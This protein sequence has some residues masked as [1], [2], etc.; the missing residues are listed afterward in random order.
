MASRTPTTS[1]LPLIPRRRPHKKSRTGCAEC[2]KRRIKCGEEKPRC[3]SCTRL[4]IPCP[5]PPAKT[6][7]TTSSLSPGTGSDTARARFTSSPHTADNAEFFSTPLPIPDLAGTDRALT[8][9]TINDLA[10]LHHWT[11]ST[12]R[13]IVMSPGVDHYWQRIFPQIAFQHPFLMH[14]IISLAALHL[15]FVHPEN[16][17]Q[18]ILDATSHHNRALEG[19]RAGLAGISDENSDALFACASVNII[20]V[21]SMYRYLYHSDSSDV[22]PTARRS[23]ILGAEWIPMIRG[24]GAVLHPVYDRVRLGPLRPLLSLGNWDE[25]DPDR[26]PSAEDEHFRNIRAVWDQSGDAEVYDK[27]LYIL[28]RCHVFIAQFRT[29]DAASLSQWGYNRDWS[30]PW[31]WLHLTPDEYF[32]KLNQRQPPALVIFV[33]FGALLHMLDE[34]WF[35]EGWGRNIVNVVDELLGEYWM[36]WTQW[37]RMVVGSA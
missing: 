25:L 7:T 1:D 24:V 17:K 4:D 5:Y 12:S 35:L 33:Y 23:Q 20:Y 34:H 37:P 19:F 13:S 14:G 28:R 15:A 2:K 32:L 16:R 29:M 18:L 11:L 36:P 27:T 26:N 9:F 31:I 21:F 30:G 10:L 22:T 3:G 8:A 6:T